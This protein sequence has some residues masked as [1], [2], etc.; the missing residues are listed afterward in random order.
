MG[1][2]LAAVYAIGVLVLLLSLLYFIKGVAA[3]LLLMGGAAVMMLAWIAVAATLGF[4]EMTLSSPHDRLTL[5]G[6]V[7]TGIAL[8]IGSV[9]LAFVER[10]KWGA[11]AIGL[12]ALT[13]AF[14][15]YRLPQIWPGAFA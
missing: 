4:L 3:D 14:L 11:L 9:Y 6:Y 8:P 12:V 7:A 10:T 5:W 1:L 2:L 15:G 13:C